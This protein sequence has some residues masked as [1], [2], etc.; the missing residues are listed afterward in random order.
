VPLSLTALCEQLPESQKKAAVRPSSS[1]AVT[2][3]PSVVP[4]STEPEDDEHGGVA[5]ETVNLILMHTTT[6]RDGYV[7]KKPLASCHDRATEQEMFKALCRTV[8]PQHIPAI[9]DHIVQATVQRADES[10]FTPRR[11]AFAT[12]LAARA[13]RQAAPNTRQ[14]AGT[15]YTSAAHLQHIKD[16]RDEAEIAEMSKQWASKGRAYKAANK[17]KI[18]RRIVTV[19][20]PAVPGAAPAPPTVPVVAPE[21]QRQAE[22]NPQV[23]RQVRRAL[24]TYDSDDLRP[25]YNKRNRS[26]SPET[27]TRRVRRAWTNV[28]IGDVSG[29]N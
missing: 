5:A 1:A 4:P 2:R 26:G 9:H 10:F 22:R 21:I 8:Q 6:H 29:A 28:K 11:Q 3:P 12:Q 20:D 25:A 24:Q 23:H 15:M 27:S 16:K 18:A 19:P 13:K 17:P 14:E 7:T